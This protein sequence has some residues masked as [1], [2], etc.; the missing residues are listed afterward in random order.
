MV[1]IDRGASGSVIFFSNFF[2][3]I[4]SIYIPKGS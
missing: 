4:K 3:K 2:S 1:E